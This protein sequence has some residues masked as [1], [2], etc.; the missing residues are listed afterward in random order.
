MTVLTAP[1]PSATAGGSAPPPSPPATRYDARA[2]CAACSRTRPA[3]LWAAA[4]PCSTAVSGTATTNVSTRYGYD[5]AGNLAAMIDAA[6]HTTAYAY[7]AAGHMTLD[8]RRRRRDLVWAYDDAGPADPPGEPL[9]PAPHELGHLDLRR[10]RA[11]A[12]RTANS[13]TTTYTYDAGGNRLTA[14]PTA[15]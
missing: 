11:H 3:D 8:H 2:G 12:T 1:D 7:D 13:V 15:P 10:R 9:R 6:G 5:A 4:D 14:R